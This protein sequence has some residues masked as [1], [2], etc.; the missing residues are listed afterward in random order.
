MVR[1]KCMLP[2]PP[3]AILGISKRFILC[4]C[5]CKYSPKSPTKCESLRINNSGVVFGILSISTCDQSDVP[6]KDRQHSRSKNMLVFLKKG[7]IFSLNF[8]HK[9]K[10]CLRISKDYL[11]FFQCNASAIFVSCQFL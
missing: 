5:L 4:S 10:S 8:E 9:G 7:F 3:M 11:F 1:V 2:A 6:E